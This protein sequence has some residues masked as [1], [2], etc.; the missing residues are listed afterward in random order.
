MICVLHVA[1]SD[2]GGSGKE[3]AALTEKKMAR[4]LPPDNTV[5]YTVRLLWFHNLLVC[6]VF[7]RKAR[8]ESRVR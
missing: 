3:V 1:D 8:S 7:K 4:S 5:T 6:Q 2:G